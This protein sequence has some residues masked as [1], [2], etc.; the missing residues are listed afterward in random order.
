VQTVAFKFTIIMTFKDIKLNLSHY[1]TSICPLL[2]L[3]CFILIFFYFLI[4]AS[5]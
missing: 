5:Q 2:W 3:Y 1:N 4:A